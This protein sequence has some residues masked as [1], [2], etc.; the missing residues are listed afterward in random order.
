MLLS[1]CSS[2]TEKLLEDISGIAAKE[3]FAQFFLHQTFFDALEFF[4]KEKIRRRR[5]FFSQ[6]HGYQHFLIKIVFEQ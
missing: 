6:V 2:V 5:I 3:S 4:V 1:F